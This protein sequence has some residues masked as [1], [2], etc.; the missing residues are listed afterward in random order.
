MLHSIEN[1]WHSRYWVVHSIITVI[2]ILWMILNYLTCVV[3][4][5]KNFW[6]V[7][8]DN[9]LFYAVIIIRIWIY[10]PLVRRIIRELLSIVGLLECRSLRRV[11]VK[12]DF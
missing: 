12:F 8:T 10:I 4:I 9:T 2:Y 7:R 11:R 6:I 5:V 3:I 1:K